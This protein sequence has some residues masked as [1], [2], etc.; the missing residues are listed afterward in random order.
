MFNI[1]KTSSLSS[2]SSKTSSLVHRADFYSEV[3]LTIVNSNVVDKTRKLL[4][5]EVEVQGEMH[6]DYTHT[7]HTV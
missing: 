7:A 4:N 1:N 6:E 3:K 2:I 5:L